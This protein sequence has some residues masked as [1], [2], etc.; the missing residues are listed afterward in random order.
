MERN[1]VIRQGDKTFHGD[2][3]AV[4]IHV[5][6]EFHRCF[7]HGCPKCYPD[8]D[9]LRHKMSDQTIR[10]VYEATRRREDALFAMS[11]SVIVMWECEWEEKKKSDDAVRAL[12]DSFGLVSRLQPQDAFFGGRTNAIKLHHRTIDDKKV[13]YHDFMSLYPWTNKNC[14]YPVGIPRSVS[15]PEAP[16]S[17]LT[18]VWSNVRFCHPTVCTILSYPI[19]TVENSRFPSVEPAWNTSNPN[20]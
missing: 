14:F 9:K 8:R 19:A 15:N 4:N 7:W 10:D 16:T 2:G 3:Y 1:H 18:L 6:Y 11:Y 12:M 20:R 17:V 13:H 5:V